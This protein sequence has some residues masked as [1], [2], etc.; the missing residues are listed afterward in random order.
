MTDTANAEDRFNEM[1]LGSMERIYER[2]NWFLHPFKARLKLLRLVS[3]RSE[4]RKYE[5][6]VRDIFLGSYDLRLDYV[7]RQAYS[8]ELPIRIVAQKYLND[9]FLSEG[10]PKEENID[11]ME[12][13]LCDEKMPEEC[14]FLAW[15]YNI[16]LAER[17]DKFSNSS[18]SLRKP[19]LNV[20]KN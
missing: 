12:N 5:G 10:H 19:Q 13:L 15:C 9:I 7:E 6:L 2:E 4:P 11:F 18:T 17:L 3:P 1:M 8:V 14:R 20:S 16:D